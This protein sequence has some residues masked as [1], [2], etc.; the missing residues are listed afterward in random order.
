GL[1]GVS[2]AC[3]VVRE[4]QPGDRRLVA[5]VV[6]AES[7]VRPAALR[8]ELG[9]VLPEYMVPTAVVV[10]DALPLLPNGKTDR[11]ALPVPDDAAAYNNDGHRPRT[12]QEDIL[13]GLFADV[14]GLSQVGAGDSFFDLGGHSLLATRLVSR[15][16]SVLGVEVQVRTLFEH[17][18]VAGL[19][20]ALTGGGL[21]RRGIVRAHRT[22][23]IPLSFAQQRLWFLNRLDGPGSTYNIPLVLDI[24]GRLDTEAL[25]A[26]LG[27]VAERHETLRTVFPEQHGDPHQ[28]VME[29][30]AA[31]PALSV[32]EVDEEALDAAVLAAVNTTFDVVTDLPLRAWLFT[33]GPGRHVLVLVVHHIAADGWSLAPLARDLGAA[34]RARVGDELAGRPMPELQYVDYTLWQRDMLGDEADPDSVTSRQLAFWREALADLPSLL[35][36]PLDRPRPVAVDHSGAVVTYTLDADLHERLRELAKSSGS[37]MFM[38]LQAAVATLLS[39]H[40]AGEDIPLGTPVAGRTDEALDDMIGFFVNTLVL[41]TNVSGNPTF[42]ELL[43]RVRQFDLAAY[44]HQDVPFE[45]LVERLNPVRA[46][47][48]HPL[49][50]TMVVLQNQ[51]TADVELPGAVVSSRLVHNGVSKFDLTFAFTEDRESG[52]LEAGIEYATSLFDASSVE[53]LAGR[54]TTLLEAVAADPDLPLLRYDVLSDDERDAVVEWGRGGVLEVP[55]GVLGGGLFGGGVGGV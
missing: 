47:N 41:R 24:E 42:R 17:P 22:D 9:H 27:D 26:A 40:G 39:R 25:R 37:T 28:F 30:G 29:A 16:R 49:F 19:A 54:L 48:H 44:A 38:V 18:T 5:Y 35:E 15:V 7:T 36:L 52:C 31:R 4:D 12:V 46:Q 20:S 50:Q 34:Y 11:R 33:A 51:E 1:P 3:V 10:L 32:Q 55:D 2:A 45:R 8:A 23:T 53:A 6:R 13:C 21:A 14:L 43:A